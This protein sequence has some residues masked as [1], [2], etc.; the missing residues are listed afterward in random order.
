MSFQQLVKK[1]RSTRRFRPEP[2]PVGFF[3]RIAEYARFSPCGG[4]TQELKFIALSSEPVCRKVF[5]LLRWARALKDW[6]GPEE[7]EQP[8]GYMVILL[9]RNISSSAGCDHGIAAQSMVL[10][11]AEEGIGSCMIGSY[12][13]PALIRELDL[14]DHLEPCLII[15]FGYPGETVVLEDVGP[16]G[17]TVYYRDEKGNHHVPKRPLDELLVK[18]L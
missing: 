6:D 5:P 1:A 4:N 15:A 16:G 7:Q 14:P 9:D 18:K 3:D 12:D 11:A 13:K 8:A 2:L 17:S 10:G